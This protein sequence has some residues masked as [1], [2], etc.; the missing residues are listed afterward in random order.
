MLILLKDLRSFG[1]VSV[2][3]GYSQNPRLKQC[4]VCPVEMMT[5]SRYVMCSGH[6]SEYENMITCQPV[7]EGEKMKKEGGADQEKDE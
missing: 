4:P 2:G 6:H 1:F 3:D 7:R 5:Q